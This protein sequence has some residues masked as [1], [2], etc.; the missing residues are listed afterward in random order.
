M[1]AHEIKIAEEAYE[2]AGVEA[3]LVVARGALRSARVAGKAAKSAAEHEVAALAYK[4]AVE[5]IEAARAAMWRA[6]YGWCVAVDEL[7]R[8]D[9]NDRARRSPY[10]ALEAGLEAG[11]KEANE[12]NGM[13]ALAYV[14]AMRA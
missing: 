2:G 7:E 13:H 5:A 14:R 6:L 12:A 8:A 3:A 11:L 10:A 1:N 4:R 9:A